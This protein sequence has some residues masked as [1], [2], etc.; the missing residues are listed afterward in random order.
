MRKFELA[1]GIVVYMDVIPGHESL[2]SDIEDSVAANA[3]AWQQ[4]GVKTYEKDGVDTNSRDTSVISVPYNPF[5]ETDF[6]SATTTF[7]GE[8]AK[9]F[10]A[11]FQ[12]I[13][14]DYMNTYGV[15]FNKHYP[16]DILK[17]GVG[18]KFNNHIDDHQDFHRRIS[19][20]YY[21]N[22]NYSGGEI[23]FPRFNVSYKPEANQ[24]IVF[25]STYT[26]NHSVD[27]VTDG[28]RYAVVSWI[29]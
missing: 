2:V 7:Y 11:N 1:P 21:I 15:N 4:A 19:T 18:Q 13:E 5:G 24:M 26:Y 10:N 14:R 6:T 20:V 3:V 22:D 9:M 28:N 25:P 29:Y 12:P 16:W 8:V 17:Y 27:P 23:N